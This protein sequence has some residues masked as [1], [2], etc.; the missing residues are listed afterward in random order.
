M[1]AGNTKRRR[2]PKHPGVVLVRPNEKARTWWRARCENPDTRGNDWITLDASLT[3]EEARRDWAV[4]KSR[5]IAKRRLELE[6]GAPRATGAGLADAVERFYKDH[7]DLRPATVWAYRDATKKLLA[8]AAGQGIESADELEGPHL[9]SFRASLMREKRTVR[10]PGG[11]KPTDEK[12]SAWTVNRELRGVATVLTYLRKHRLL[13]RLSSDAIKDGLEKLRTPVEP[14]EYLRPDEIR[15]LLEAC[16]QHDEARF[17]ETRAEHAGQGKPGETLRH[18]KIAPLTVALL[19]TGARLGEM[20]TL[21][22]ERVYLDEPG[23]IRLTAATKTGRGRIIDLAVCPALREMLEAMKPKPAAGLVF[24]V[25]RNEAQ[26][27]HRRLV[28]TYGAPAGSNW[29]ALRATC[30]TYLTCAP[31]IFGAASAYH[32]AKQLGHSVAIA[33]KHYVGR[34]RN[35]LA[36]ARTLDDAMQIR[37]Q[38]EKI[39]DAIS[40]RPAKPIA[41]KSA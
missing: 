14:A 25:T 18:V 10:G 5:A 6:G 34:I 17:A 16:M 1:K 15:R 29:H 28:A 12:R 32:S 36:T 31:G 26:A 23:E 7:P 20:L 13:S 24:G 27:A 33:E 4:R 35:I 38:L 21:T 41:S 37:S 11:R 8:W 39:I 3:T 40:D 19:L 22:W 9:L 30:G 2:G